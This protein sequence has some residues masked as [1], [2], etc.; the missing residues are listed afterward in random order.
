MVKLASLTIRAVHVLVKVN[1]LPGPVVGMD[2]VLLLQLVVAMCENALSSEL[3]LAHLPVPTY[4]CFKFLPE[5]TDRC[6]HL[7]GLDCLEL[8]V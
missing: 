2:V 6:D 7:F 5:I 3:A 8:H 1:A 4:F